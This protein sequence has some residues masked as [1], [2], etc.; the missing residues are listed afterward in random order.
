V[1]RAG[2]LEL[3]RKVAHRRLDAAATAP[4]APALSGTTR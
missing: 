4:Q 3:I 1:L 2:V